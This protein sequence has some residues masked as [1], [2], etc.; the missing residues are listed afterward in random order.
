[1]II[2]TIL[3]KHFDP[4]CESWSIYGRQGADFGIFISWGPM[5][6]PFGYKPI[7]PDFQGEKKREGGGG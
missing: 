1:M 5:L 7:I 6:F 2:K 4:I 3:E